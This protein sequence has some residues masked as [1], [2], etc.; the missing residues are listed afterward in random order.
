[1][2]VME[3]IVRV[4]DIREDPQNPNVMDSGKFEALKKVIGKYGFLVPVILNR[5]LVIA[6]GYHRWKA[7]KDLGM[8]EIKAV[9]LDIG[10]VDRRMIRQ[11]M[12]KLRGE[13]DIRKDID[14]FES[15]LKSSGSFKEFSELMAQKESYFD[16]MMK[17][18]GAEMEQYIM[19]R[20]ADESLKEKV[21]SF[22]QLKIALTKEQLG[23]IREK[24]GEGGKVLEIV[25]YFLVL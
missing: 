6:D 13:H 1:M 18:R 23:K 8:E 11:I 3:R 10:E 16:E 15:I 9:V 24:F 25:D 19:V 7:A 12:N 5:D 4:S 2:N 14:E 20:E 22:R 21:G 17:M